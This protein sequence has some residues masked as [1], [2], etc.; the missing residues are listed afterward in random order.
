[1]KPSLKTRRSRIHLWITTLA[2]CPIM[3]GADCIGH[4]TLLEQD[5]PA[6]LALPQFAD[7]CP[8]AQAAVTASFQADANKPV[9][10][11]VTGPSSNSR[12]QV[13][14]IDPQGNVV[15]NSGM[16]PTNRMVT[17]NF[18]PTASLTYDIE[19]WECS[20]ALPGNYKVHVTQAPL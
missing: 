9:L 15:A 2:A 7:T 1:M 19:V 12:P 13:I 4:G 11:T 5:L 3:M 6:F 16:T 8:T 18:S 20:G 10:V 14:V 17:A